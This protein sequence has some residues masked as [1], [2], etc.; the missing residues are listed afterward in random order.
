[1]SYKLGSVS[2]LEETVSP[3]EEAVSPLEESQKEE[4]QK[5]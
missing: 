1:M 2:P 5:G 4:S 3:L